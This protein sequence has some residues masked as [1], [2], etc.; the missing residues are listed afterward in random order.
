VCNTGQ[1]RSATWRCTENPACND[2]HQL[3]ALAVEACALCRDRRVSCVNI[4]APDAA[5]STFVQL[6]PA[7]LLQRLRVN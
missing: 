4:P 2:N 1:L 5:S 7:D 3:I 6:P